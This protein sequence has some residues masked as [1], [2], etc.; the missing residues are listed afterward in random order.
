MAAL[1]AEAADDFPR[2]VDQRT[3]GVAVVGRSVKLNDIA[4]GQ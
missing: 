2:A 3:A 4:H 1:A